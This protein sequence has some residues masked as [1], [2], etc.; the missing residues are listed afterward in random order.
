MPAKTLGGSNDEALDAPRG[1]T[2]AALAE[3]DSRVPRGFP[4]IDPG[5]LDPAL[6]ISRPPPEPGEAAQAATFMVNLASR[7]V[8]ECAEYPTVEFSETKPVYEDWSGNF[9]VSVAL[10]GS[11]AAK[12]VNPGELGARLLLESDGDV[13][14]DASTELGD[15]LVGL[16]LKWVPADVLSG[17][18]APS[19]SL[20]GSIP[21]GKGKLSGGLDKDGLQVTY[22]APPEK[23]EIAGDLFRWEGS[24]GWSVL[25]P[26]GGGR[27]R[28]RPE[29]Q[30][31]KT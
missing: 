31:A 4:G 27:R 28:D 21:L 10:N 9:K 22:K 5:A 15:A 1:G 16:Q 25:P 30:K 8:E 12:P 17:K 24:L 13:S 2:S 19:L 11:L 6:G 14:I 23:V 7:M 29:S 3:E 26:D 20:G 18:A